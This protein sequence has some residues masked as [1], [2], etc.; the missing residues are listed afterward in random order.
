MIRRLCSVTGRVFLVFLLIGQSQ[1]FAQPEIPLGEWRTHLS[2][3]SIHSLTHSSEKIFGATDGGIVIFDK[4][5]NSLSTQ[6]KL[7]GLSGT[8]I[9]FVHYDPATAYLIVAYADGNLDLIKDDEVIN[10]D[11]L[12]NSNLI[13]GSKKINH[14]STRNG[15]AYIS[16]DFGLVV[17]D[18]SK[19]E[20]KETWRDIGPSGEIP[21]VRSSTFVGD[22]IFI[23]TDAGVQTG[24]INKNL[25]DFNNWKRFESGVFSNDVAGVTTFNSKIYTAIDGVGVLSYSNGSWTQQSYLAGLNYNFITAGPNYLFIG[26]NTNLWTVDNNN[27][28]TA[29]NPALVNV[30]QAAIEDAQQKLWI[31]DSK[32]GMVSNLTGAFTDHVVNG[33]ATNAHFRLKYNNRT[34]YAMSGGFSPTGNRLGNPRY[35]SFFDNGQWTTEAILVGDITD[36]EF[37]S[38]KKYV[39][40]FGD[41]IEVDDESGNTAVLNE[42]N[43]PLQKVTSPDG[44]FVTA[45]E[46]NSQGLWVS[47]YRA[48]QALRL[49]NNDGIWE[50]FSLISPLARYATEIK[51]DFSN[52][53]WLAISPSV[54]GGLIVYNKDEN[55]E[56]YLFETTGAG[57]L[58]NR[59]VTS[60]AIDRGGYVWVGTQ[61][62]VAYFYDTDEDAVKPIFENRFLLRD[63]KI[64]AIEVDGGNRKWIGTER[65]VW[66]FN[67]EGEELILNFTEDNSPLLSNRIQDIEINS[68]TGEVFFATDKGIVSYRGDATASTNEFESVKIFP[69]PVTNDFSGMVSISGLATDSFVKIT[70]ISG[71]LIWQ[72]QA[73][74]GTATWNV[75]DYNGT[76]AATGV[77]IV[78]AANLDGSE[79]VAGKIV[80]VE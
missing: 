69:N 14:I 43:S 41:G 38:E 60:L 20:L 75:R 46:V 17:F 13:T 21:Q 37:F 56:D 19:A 72:T 31:G 18:L 16:A 5:D 47:N 62:G 7:T 78:F 11:R 59:N 79:S 25:L 74:G 63:E 32:N 10:F 55:H 76:R 9:T 58:P 67:S 26:A 22:S 33:P 4:S 12:K 52:N 49:L 15:F 61:Q 35:L 57:N 2:Y 34:M 27:T 36:I 51:S 68:A 29:I 80:V 73:S 54:G 48:T 28:V 66:L 30:P 65:G 1:L 8:G 77:Y 39:S 64:T 53:V 3:N 42:L 6:T 70:D 23:A 44:V 50:S 45:L 24:N 71:K 40:S